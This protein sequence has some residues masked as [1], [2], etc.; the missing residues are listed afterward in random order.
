MPLDFVRLPRLLL[1]A[2]QVDLHRFAVIACDQFTSEPRYW[3]Q[4]AHL[5]GDAPSALHLMLPEIHLD[6][7]DTYLPRIRRAMREAVQSCL[8]RPLPAGLMLVE[9][10]TGRASP[11]RGVLLAFDLEAYDETPDRKSVV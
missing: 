10:H 2:P 6:K 8:L 5:V 9:R 7:A 11:R 4:T 1:P 3:A